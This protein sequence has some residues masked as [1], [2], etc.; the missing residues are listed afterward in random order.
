MEYYY[1]VAED[2][3]KSGE[4]YADS[5]L[6]FGMD[7]YGRDS[8]SHYNAGVLFARYQLYDLARREFGLALSQDP[9]HQPSKDALKRLYGL[10]VGRLPGSP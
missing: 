7:I 10:G 3:L 5:W 2:S 1:A 6:K 8:T 4:F 9:Y